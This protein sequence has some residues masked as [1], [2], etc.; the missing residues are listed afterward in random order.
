MTW[1]DLQSV[2][3]IK[4][5]EPSTDEFLIAK[6]FES[7]E[8]KKA[9]EAL[10]KLAIEKPALVLQNDGVNTAIEMAMRE[11]ETNFFKK[12]VYVINKVRRYYESRQSE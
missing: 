6:V 8:G 4:H 12:I 1:S 7:E 10:K 9:L 2:K 5:K 11:G 3:E